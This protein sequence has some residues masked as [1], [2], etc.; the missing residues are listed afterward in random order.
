MPN[1]P[2]RRNHGPALAF[3]LRLVLRTLDS[4]P[5]NVCNGDL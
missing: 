5:A 1:E 3:R 2:T 4:L